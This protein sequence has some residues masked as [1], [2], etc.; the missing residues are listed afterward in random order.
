ME[1]EIRH[2]GIVT[3]KS[4]DMVTVRIEQTSACAGCHA[5]SM[6]MSADKQ[7]KDID[8][9]ASGTIAVGD[10]VEV[11]GSS[12][13]SW[14]AVLLAYV[15]PF[16]ILV[17]AVVAMDAMGYSE[18][19]AGLLAIAFAAVYYVVLTLLRNKMNTMFSF[20]AKPCKDNNL[21]KENN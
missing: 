15:L 12:G 19:L 16:I 7:E 4:G 5:A 8:A 17:A 1:D 6:C 2:T 20:V 18:W 21:E 9:L 11:I 10:Y 14:L 13:Q 3:A